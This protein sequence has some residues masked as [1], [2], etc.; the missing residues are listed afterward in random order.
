M[1]YSFQTQDILIPIRRNSSTAD[2]LYRRAL[3]T[4]YEGNKKRRLGKRNRT[5]PPPLPGIATAA[6]APSF[7]IPTDNQLPGFVSWGLPTLFVCG[8]PAQ[9]QTPI[10]QNLLQFGWISNK[11]ESKRKVNRTPR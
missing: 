9:L 4:G 6:R 2:S 8:L 11:I 7:F 5:W 1:T 3:V 10:Q